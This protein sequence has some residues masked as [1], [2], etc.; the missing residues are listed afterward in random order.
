MTPATSGR[1]GT[2]HATA[3]LPTTATPAPTV[4]VVQPGSGPSPA[5]VAAS[6]PP[7]AR[8]QGGAGGTQVQCG[9]RSWSV[10]GVRGGLRA[11]RWAGHGCPLGLCC[12]AR[13]PW[14]LWGLVVG[15]AR[16]TLM[17]GR[18][19]GPVLLLGLA[20]LGL[21]AVAAGIPIAS[22]PAS[23]THMQVPPHLSQGG[24]GGDCGT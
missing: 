24:G 17:R 5:L 16:L 2:P 1:A 20:G 12:P 18:G 9:P 10:F 7:W 15:R 6:L 23:L 4:D 13:V 19:A 3:H 22:P 8:S 11:C 21:W 14:S